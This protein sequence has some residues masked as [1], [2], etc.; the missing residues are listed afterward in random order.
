MSSTR[1]T[2]CRVNRL[3]IL[4]A[5]IFTTPSAYPQSATVTAPRQVVVGAQIKIGW[6]GPE[7]A[8]DF[9][10]IDEVGAPDQSYGTY[11]YTRKGQPAE[12]RA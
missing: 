5:L 2:C 4:F 7:G 1:S 6:N 9:I 11:I 3:T 12:I 10:S 8:Y